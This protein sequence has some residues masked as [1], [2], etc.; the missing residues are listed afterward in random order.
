MAAVQELTAMACCGADSCRK[1]GLELAGLGAGGDP[2]GAN[3]FGD[4][5]DFG[6]VGIW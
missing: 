1:F 3:G 5:V 4:C 6:F 2:A